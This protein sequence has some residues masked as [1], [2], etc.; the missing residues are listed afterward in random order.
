MTITEFLEPFGA[1][2]IPSTYQ[3]DLNASWKFPIAG[4]FSGSVLIEALNVTDR[5]ALT[6]V[7]NAGRISGDPWDS[8]A[9]YNIQNPREYRAL[10]TLSF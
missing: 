7:A 4:R 3:V 10:L 8:V 9:N 2:R 5:Q 6:S 1:R